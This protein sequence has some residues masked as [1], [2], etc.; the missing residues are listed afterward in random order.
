MHSRIEH[1][2]EGTLFSQELIDEITEILNFVYKDKCELANKTIE[3][4]GK[5][6]DTE[7]L[8]AI[9]VLEKEDENAIPATY[10]A[11]AEIGTKKQDA[12]LDAI[13]DSAG[14]F[15]EQYLNTPN[16]DGYIS[17]WTEEEIKGVQIYYQVTRENI[18]LSLMADQLLNQ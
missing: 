9:T 3:V 13:V 10:I 18:K 4:Y 17:N 2:Q 15:I 7:L 12:I 1:E 8:L 11:S 14:I 6:Y 5:T 16:W